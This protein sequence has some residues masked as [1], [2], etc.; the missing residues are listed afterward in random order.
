MAKPKKQ[1]L[2]DINELYDSVQKVYKGHYEQCYD[3]H[4]HDAFNAVFKRMRGA[5]RVKVPSV[6]YCD[7]CVNRG[8]CTVEDSF[9]FA[10]IDKP[11][12]CVGKKEYLKG[13]G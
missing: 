9:R 5:K 2:V 13:L 8:K 10:R 4:M 1:E 12:C 7:E 3:Q 6:V 11:F